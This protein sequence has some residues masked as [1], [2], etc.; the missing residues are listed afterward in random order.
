MHGDGS[1]KPPARACGIS[2][3][4]ANPKEKAKDKKATIG[5]WLDAGPQAAR[6][7]WSHVAASKGL[8][9]E[10]WVFIADPAQVEAILRDEKRFSVSEY[11]RRMRATSG[12]FYLGMDPP[13]HDRDAA[14]GAII[15]SWNQY[16]PKGPPDQAALAPVVQAA[17]DA[18]RDALGKAGLLGVLAKKT[19]DDARCRMT[20]PQLFGAVLDACASQEFGIAGPS[21]LSLIAW[22]KE[23]TWYH[24]RV[25]AN[26]GADRACAREASGQYAAHVKAQIATMKEEPADP[27][28][29]KLQEQVTKLREHCPCA[30]DEDVARVLTNILTGALTATAKA[31]SD[32]LYLYARQRG[33]QFVW[34]E[35]FDNDS[36]MFPLYEQIVAQTLADFQRG[37]LDSV[38]RKFVASDQPPAVSVELKT[39]DRVIVWLGGSLTHDRD[40]LFGIGLHKCPGMDMAKAMIEGALR[41]LTQLTQSSPPTL[42]REDE[43]DYLV[44]AQPALLLPKSKP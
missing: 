18:C 7:F 1:S 41:A 21:S 2:T 37:S 39:G 34:P 40:N 4:L 6:A 38:Y 19:D 31:F 24:F 8:R 20:F 33:G 30:S 36:T 17:E 16:P 5:K 9:V 3:Y 29:D 10:D 44:F 13:Q 15:P 32:A 27:R 11:D 14:M 22:A 25:Y 35:R 23:L 12:R 42:E 26:E 43:V 28:K